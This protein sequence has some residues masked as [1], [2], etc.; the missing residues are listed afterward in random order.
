MLEGHELLELLRELLVPCGV[1]E[2]AWSAV[3]ECLVQLV[4]RA[5]RP[6]RDEDD[7]GFTRCPKG[8]DI[9]NPVFGKDADAIPR[10]ERAAIGP[11]P[12]ALQGPPIEFCISE[13]QAR[14]N[15]DQGDR[16]GAK[17]GALSE[18]VAGDHEFSPD[19]LETG[20]AVADAR[21]E[22]DARICSKTCVNSR[23]RSS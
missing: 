10:D 16:V 17:T 6:E 15:V 22:S 5:A 18:N 7:A 8:I 14:G 23:G 12:R 20:C 3:R 1:H 19:R 2:A 4:S 11:D 13:L 21:D 9:F